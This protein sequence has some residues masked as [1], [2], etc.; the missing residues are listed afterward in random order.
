[1]SLKNLHVM[2]NVHPQYDESKLI[3]HIRE[4]ERKKTDVINL[5]F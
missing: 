1:M 2:Y 4:K 3:N 5:S